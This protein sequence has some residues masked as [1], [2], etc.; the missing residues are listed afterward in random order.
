MKAGSLVH[1]AEVAGNRIALVQVAMK[2]ALVHGAEK[3]GN[4]VALAH[5]AEKAGNRVVAAAAVR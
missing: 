4:K 5:G 2:V 1:R 3:V